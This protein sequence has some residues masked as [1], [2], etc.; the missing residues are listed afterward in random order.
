MEEATRIL[1]ISVSAMF[2]AHVASGSINR[3]PF[4]RAEG[5]TDYRYPNALCSICLSPSIWNG[6]IS[7]GRSR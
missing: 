5:A 6:F 3:R 1:L 2:V 7:L 4:P